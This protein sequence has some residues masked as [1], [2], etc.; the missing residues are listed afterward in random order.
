MI[1]L[2]TLVDLF[3]PSSL[4][5]PPD[6][7][8]S[9]FECDVKSVE[10]FISQVGEAKVPAAQETFI[11]TLL[12][13]LTDSGVGIYDSYHDKA[14]RYCGYESKEATRLAFLYVVTD[15]SQTFFSPCSVQVQRLA[16]R[17]ENWQSASSRC[18]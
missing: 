10:A 14:V 3:K 11:R 7:L 1:W 12:G 17:P 5:L 13:G 6:D 8:S 18:T 15:N 16:G 9:N 2:K 4:V